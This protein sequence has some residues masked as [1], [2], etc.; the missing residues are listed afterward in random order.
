MPW[1]GQ[2]SKRKTSSRGYGAEHQAERKRRLPHYTEHDPCGN[3]GQPLG[4]NRKLWHLPHNDQRTGYLPGFWCAACNVK[5]G[6]RRGRARQS[7]GRVT[8]L[9]W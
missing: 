3:C 1:E 9:V 2:R 8:E 6:A 4:P 5:D 7:Q